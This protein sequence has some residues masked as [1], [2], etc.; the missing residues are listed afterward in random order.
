MGR[1]SRYSG[2]GRSSLCR[3]SMCFDHKHLMKWS[4]EI[5]TLTDAELVAGKC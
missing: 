2:S 1:F 5:V 4:G 3:R